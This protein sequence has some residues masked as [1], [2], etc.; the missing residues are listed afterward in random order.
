LDSS[1][2]SEISLYDGSVPE[3]LA[4][5]EIAVI[6]NSVAVVN[7][8][9][10][11]GLNSGKKDPETGEKLFG[12]ASEVSLYA[13]GSQLVGET[14]GS[15]LTMSIDSKIEPKPMFE[16]EAAGIP[17][18]AIFPLTMSLCGEDTLL[19]RAVAAFMLRL[20]SQGSLGYLNV[21]QLPEGIRYEAVGLVR[22][23]LPTPTVAP[24]SE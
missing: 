22:K 6:P 4:D 10:T 2:F 20:D 18:Q 9:L 3:P 11:I 5:G 16:G 1:K 19:K 13:A 12:V 15:T 8:L 24:K 23:G 14:N 17:Y 21:S 7:G